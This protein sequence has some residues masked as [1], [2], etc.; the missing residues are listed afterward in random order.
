MIAKLSVT[1]RC[2]AQCQTCPVW[3][4]PGGDM[5]LKVFKV[6]WDKLMLHPAIGKIL[7]NSTGDMYNHPRRKEIW[8]YVEERILKWVSMTTNA[9]KMDYVPK[10]PEIIISFNGSNKRGY[11]RTTGLPFHETVQKIKAH[12]P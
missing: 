1:T 2:N 6:V 9:A 11:E 8:A 10:I 5:P 7:I 3:S 4:I 12:Y